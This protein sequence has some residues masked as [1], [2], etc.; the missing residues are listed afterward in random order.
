[1][2]WGP[3]LG[4]VVRS[5]RV[6]S[7]HQSSGRKL[8]VAVMQFRKVAWSPSGTHSVSV[9]T[10]LSRRGLPSHG[11]VLRSC[12]ILAISR[13]YPGSVPIGSCCLR[14]PLSLLPH[15]PQ[16]HQRRHLRLQARQVATTARPVD[17]PWHP[18]HP[19]AY[20]KGMFGH[21]CRLARTR[22]VCT[23]YCP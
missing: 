10:S 2:V 17:F 6:G 12:H 23:L 11:K 8:F 15:R 7:S 21:R 22:A 3:V 14:L 1:M 16:P 20:Q 19:G 9:S 13:C 5:T 4:L 18:V